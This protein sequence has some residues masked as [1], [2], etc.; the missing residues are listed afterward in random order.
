MPSAVACDTSVLVPA[1]LGWHEHHDTA[2]AALRRATAVPAHVLLETYS[3]LT[4]LPDPRRPAPAIAAAALRALSLKPLA[5]P[6]G[7]HLSLLDDL[8]RAGISG[9]AAYDAVIGAT[10]SHH[11]H[12][13]L[14]A[15]QR[16]RRTYAAVGVEVDLVGG[17][18]EA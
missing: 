16:A 2:H 6:A 7:A 14:T 11:R 15:D 5:L 1:L 18:H 9:A 8:A 12:L 17:A 13:L 10:A 4:R 3:V